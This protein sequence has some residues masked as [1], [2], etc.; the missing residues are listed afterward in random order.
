[1]HITYDNATYEALLL[2]TNKSKWFM[3]E[4]YQFESLQD[5]RKVNVS[6]PCFVLKF[7]SLKPL[8]IGTQNFHTTLTDY[9]AHSATNLKT[10]LDTV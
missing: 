1:M 5:V 3:S 9:S 2:K 8:S 10:T 7:G 6:T 4:G